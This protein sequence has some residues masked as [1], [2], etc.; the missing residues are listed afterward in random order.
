MENNFLGSCFAV[1]AAPWDLSNPSR[2]LSC[3]K[4]AAA[5]CRPANA[6]VEAAEAAPAPSANGTAAKE[7][8]VKG[9]PSLGPKPKGSAVAKKEAAAAN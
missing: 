4:L 1:C 9:L 7:D 3:L 6:Q 2:H 5:D 8:K